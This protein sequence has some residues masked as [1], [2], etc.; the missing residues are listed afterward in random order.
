MSIPTTTGSVG[1]YRTAFV[2][3]HREDNT[4]PL[5]VAVTLTVPMSLEDLTATLWLIVVREGLADLAEFIH[6]PAFTHEMICETLLAHG[7]EQV[8]QARAEVAGIRPGHEHHPVLM[9]LRE[10]VTQLYTTG[11]TVAPQRALAGVAR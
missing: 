5:A 3:V 1:R 10:L 8:N 6:D 9:Q 2:P 11:P 7:G 4:T